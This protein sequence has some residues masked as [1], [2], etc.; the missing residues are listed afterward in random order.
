M[1]RKDFEK[2]FKK[3][4]WWFDR[5]GGRHDIWTNG[6][7]EFSIP[8]HRGVTRGVGEDG[9]KMIKNFPGPKGAKEDKVKGE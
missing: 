2:R 9:L 3:A 4:G 5:P 1:K 6:E 8:R 7:L